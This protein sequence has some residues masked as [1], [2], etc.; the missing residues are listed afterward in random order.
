MEKL[1]VVTA[2]SNS[3]RY[4]VRAELYKKFAKHVEDSGAILHT[5]ELAFGD[6]PFE[7]TESDNPRH[8]QFRTWD[9]LWHKENIQ[10]RVINRLPPDAQYILC[11]DSDLQWADPEWA[12]EIVQALQHFQIIQAFSQSID[13][14]PKHEVVD[15]SVGMIYDMRRCNSYYPERN[16]WYDRFPK[17]KIVKCRR[18]DG[19]HYHERC[20]NKTVRHN[21]PGYCWAYR[22]EALDYLGG[23]ME[24]PILGSADRHMAFAL[25]N[26]VHETVNAK[27][28]RNYHE[29]SRIWQERAHKHIKRDV[30]WLNSTVFHYH[31]GNKIDRKYHD[32]WRILVDYQYDPLRHVKH[33]SQGILQWAES[34]PWGLRDGCR[35]YFASR[36]EDSI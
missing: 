35:D 24:F 19:T 29:Q 25:F 21:H 15:H 26:R 3:P 7:V 12:D 22:R 8:Y 1:H 31:H 27:M 23:L 36:N 20:H 34:A 32:R 2:I 30:G 16:D 28:H 11:A 10:N 17:E 4:H 33:D 13:F 6:R 5:G 18:K 14:G 9:E